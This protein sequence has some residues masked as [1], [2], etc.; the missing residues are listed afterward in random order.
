MLSRGESSDNEYMYLDFINVYGINESRSSGDL[1]PPAYIYD[2]S[3]TG[4]QACV[5]IYGQPVGNENTFRSY[6]LLAKDII[7][8]ID[9]YNGYIRRG[10][11][12][13]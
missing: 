1:T 8:Y 12:D 3:Q 6:L 4:Q 13:F 11:Q 10:R 2:G 7:V 5:I 9:G